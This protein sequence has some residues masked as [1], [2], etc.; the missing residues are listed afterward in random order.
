[1]VTGEGDGLLAGEGDGRLAGE[2]DGLLTWE[3]DGLLIWKGDGLLTGEGDGLLTGR[4]TACWW[5]GRRPAEGGGRRPADRW[6]R[7]CWVWLNHLLFSIFSNLFCS[8]EANYSVLLLRFLLFREL[9]MSINFN[10]LTEIFTNKFILKLFWTFG[11]ENLF[12]SCVYFSFSVSRHAIVSRDF[13]LLIGLSILYAWVTCMVSS[14]L[15]II[16]LTLVNSCVAFTV[17]FSSTNWWWKYF[18]L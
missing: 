5:G 3:G 18:L 17:D 14:T 2:G 4:T 8:F 16:W 7:G 1:M 15:C 12:N 6:R 10:I 11:L 13:D 9:F